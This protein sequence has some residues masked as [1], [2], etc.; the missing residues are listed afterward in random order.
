LNANVIDWEGIKG[1]LFLARCG[2]QLEPL[3]TTA[4]D[5]ETNPPENKVSKDNS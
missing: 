3:R 1:S 5:L 4:I 2:L